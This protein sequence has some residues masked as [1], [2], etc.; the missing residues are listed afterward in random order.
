MYRLKFADEAAAQRARELAAGMSDQ[1]SVD[2]NYVMQRPPQAEML[3]A[4]SSVPFSLNPSV[5]GDGSKFIVGLIDTQIQSLGKQFDQFMLPA[6]SALGEISPASS[7]YISH[8]SS[9][10]ETI[11][12]GLATILES[13][14]SSTRILPV[15]VY[16]NNA[17]ASS[18]DVA[19]GIYMAVQDGG[20][21][22]IN[23]SLGS[24]ADPS[25]LHTIIQNASQKGVLFIASAGNDPV[26][27]PLYPAAW[28]EVISATAGDKQGNLASYANRSSTVDVLAPGASIVY[29][30]NT[31]YYVSG[32]S[33]SA[34]WVSGMAAA[35]ANRTGASLTD[36][37]AQLLRVLAAPTAKP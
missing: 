27:T 36:V 37:K 22:L 13:G 33:V 23:L 30:N 5:G 3:A 31:A 9:M 32:T 10:A 20:A 19:K 25:Y 24:E 4:S 35:I 17:N 18:F 34:A 11:L 16:G 21:T 29:F 14:N 8:G 26:T 28:P 1:V 2:S 12:K 6:L 7:D 15:D